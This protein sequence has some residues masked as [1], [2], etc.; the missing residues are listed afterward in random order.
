MRVIKT[1]VIGRRCSAGALIA[2]AVGSAVLLS[3]AT[4]NAVPDPN[5]P[6]ADPRAQCE[7][8]EVGGVFISGVDDELPRSVCQYI[9][10]GYAYYDNY[11]N[12]A[13]TGTTVYRDG[14]QMPTERPATSA[15]IQLPA[16]FPLMPF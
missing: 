5:A 6:A 16:R 15:P 8:R 4:A 7:S 13:Y 1:T 10:E 9:V 14:A 11:E 3:A 2:C 12:G